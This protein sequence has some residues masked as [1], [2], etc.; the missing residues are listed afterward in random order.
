MTTTDGSEKKA[1]ASTA[2]T[3]LRTPIQERQLGMSQVLLDKGAVVNARDI[4][5]WTALILAA[6]A[7]YKEDVQLLL[8]NAAKVN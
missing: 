2:P 3:G 4:E 5:R 8:E 1:E 7:G 6:Q